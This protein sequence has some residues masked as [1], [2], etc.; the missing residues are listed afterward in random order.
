[1]SLFDVI[2]YPITGEFEV[3]DLERIP[4]YIL[5]EWWHDCFGIGAVPE[6]RSLNSA[7][8]I[9]SDDFKIRLLAKLKDRLNK[10]DNL[11]CD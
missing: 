1:M 10:H 4:V 2:K 9:C 8:S 11:P 7:L 3:E 5:N 6:L